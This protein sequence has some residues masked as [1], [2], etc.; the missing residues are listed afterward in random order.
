M[1]DATQPDAVP[2]ASAAPIQ[3]PIATGPAA[4]PAPAPAAGAAPVALPDL[5][6][7]VPNV[8][9]P[10]IAAPA[11]TIPTV[12]AGGASAPEATLPP[13]LAALQNATNAQAQAADEEGTAKKDKDDA[14]AQAKADAEVQHRL[15]AQEADDLRA[16]HSQAAQAAEN[17][18][19]RA[20]EVARDAKIPDFWAGRE[21][22]RTSAALAVGLGGFAAGLLGS[23]RN[24]AADIIQNNVDGYY[25][26]EKERIDNLYKYAEGQGRAQ[27]D[28]RMRQAAELAELQVQHG[29]TNLAIADHIDEITAAS[30]GR[31][32]I[33]QANAL[34][35]KVVADGQESILKGR[36]SLAAIELK[37]KQGELAAAKAQ[38]AARVG[39]G[40]GAGSGIAANDAVLKLKQAIIDGTD[41]GK[42]GKRALN[43]A[44]IQQFVNDNKLPIPATAKAGHSSVASI[45]KDVQFVAKTAS[46]HAAEEAKSSGFDPKQAYREDGK[47]VGYVPAGRGGAAAFGQNMIKYSSALRA[48]QELR[49][50]SVSLGGKIPKGPKLDAAVLAIAS[51]TKANGSD[52]TTQH[53][54]GTLLNGLG[55]VSTPAIDTKIAE[56]K[57]ERKE[58]LGQLIPPPSSSGDDRKDRA[59]AILG[60]PARASKLTPG[61]KAKLEAF[62]HG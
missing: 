51:T 11:A 42:G 50:A 36:A 20:L 3:G 5:P 10:A 22:A 1:A 52:R 53:E 56:L 15:Q 14:E 48:L 30:Q 62:V 38:R 23:S 41:D 9:A 6:G 24:G 8:P 26:R 46:E 2:D 19:Q 49:D 37:G 4:L 59:K 45:T 27:D 35:A 31:I 13:E 60:D 33:A 40:G 61:D 55:F 28:L 32:D 21:G 17:R 39:A 7:G 44:E 12:P 34:K 57:T 58:I 47:I 29:A 16:A 25:R 43:A 18:T 54:E